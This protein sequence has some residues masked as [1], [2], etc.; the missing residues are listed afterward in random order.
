MSR[1]Q[2]RSRMKARAHSAA[3][4]VA[5]WP[6]A[7]FVQIERLHQANASRLL[8]PYDLHHR[9]WRILALLGEHASLPINQNAEAAAT[10]R[11]T[12]SKM[13]GRLE[14]RGLVARGASEV[15]G[16][17]SPVSLTPRGTTLLAET[18]PL[19]RGLFEQYRRGLSAASHDQLMR[20]LQTY[21]RQ[22][23]GIAE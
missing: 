13:I 15:D 7:H 11:S 19:V 17:A 16:R 20:L 9:E 18:A 22:V 12:V 8:R 10:D 14:A 23:A 5:D 1:T 6:M 2:T 3:F 4:R 21:R